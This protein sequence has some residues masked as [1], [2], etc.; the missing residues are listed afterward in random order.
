MSDYPDAS[1][2]AAAD[3]AIEDV[4]DPGAA[5]AREEQNREHERARQQR[6][7]FLMQ[8]MQHPE[9]RKWL[10]E[11]LDRFHTFEARMASVN[12]MA[13]D[14]MGTMLLAGEQ[15]C[16]WWIWEQLDDA[17]PVVASRLRRNA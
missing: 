7:A 2:V 9:G 10:K 11:M 8:T 13:P 3:A 15:R 1:R 17:D 16:G 14:P 4:L 6:R 5:A 12:G